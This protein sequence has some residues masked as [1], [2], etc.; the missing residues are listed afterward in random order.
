MTEE[1]KSRR[2][3]EKGLVKRLLFGIN[4]RISRNEEWSEVKDILSYIPLVRDLQAVSELIGIV[5]KRP[6]LWFNHG[7]D[8]IKEYAWEFGRRYVVSAAVACAALSP[9]VFYYM[10]KYSS[11]VDKAEQIADAN[12]DGE[13]DN[14]EQVRFYQE[15]GMP[16][17]IRT[18]VCPTEGQFRRENLEN[19]IER[20]NA[21]SGT[22]GKK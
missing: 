18:E 9:F 7:E 2:G 11:L 5:K 17:E 10:S 19:Y 12:H 14:E 15:V 4:E 3:T 20:S 8:V 13:L 22:G 21:G 1:N 16:F 6:G